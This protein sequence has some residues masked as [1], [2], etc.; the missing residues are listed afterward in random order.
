M[1]NETEKK[2]GKI[3]SIQFG[4][5][6]YQDAMLGLHVTLGGDG[7]GVGHSDCTWD[8]ELVKVGSHTKWTDRDRDKTYA[9]IMRRVSKL[10]KDAKVSHVEQLKGVPVEVTFDRAG[11]G[12]TLT[13]WRILTEVL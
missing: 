9:D 13:E 7:W 8:A 4:I 10:L 6:G 2:I 11:L 12:A 1:T 3:K 5:G